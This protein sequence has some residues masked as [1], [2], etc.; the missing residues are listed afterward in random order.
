MIYAVVIIAVVVALAGVTLWKTL[1]LKNRTDFLVAGRKL[2]WTVLVFTLLSSWIGAGSLF[3]GGENAYRN[4]FAALWQPAGGWLG[5]VVIAFIAGRARRFAQFTVPDLLEKRYN[6]T[7]RVLGTIAI[8]ISYTVITS[9]QFKGGG[10]IMHM[11]FPDMDRTTGM[12]IVALF[13]IVFT[14][15][16]GMASVAYMDLVIGALVTVIVV[17]AVPL[18]LSSA[19]GWSGV[20]AS[21]PETHFQVLGNLS[22]SQALGF[23]IPTMLLLVG[24]QGMYQKFFS[25]R[26]ERDAKLAVGGWIV[27]TLLLEALLIALAVIGSA[28][29]KTEAPREIIPITARL[30]LPTI[31]GA[32]LLGGIFAKIIST[33]NNYLFSPATNL[34]HDVYERFIDRNASDRRSLIVSRI[35]VVALGMFALL[36]ASHFES[37]LRAALYAYTVYGAAVTPAVLAVFFWRRTTTAG[38]IS[39]ILLGTI[40]T[41]AWNLFEI[42]TLDAIYPALGASVA[43]LI[44]VSLLTPAPPPERVAPF[45]SEPV[46]FQHETH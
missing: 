14:A 41:V 7:A 33:A 34:I 21:L 13:V 5:L 42:S 9:Y 12:Y 3:A 31:I 28:K 27:G 11:I 17:I 1:A 22:L 8:V 43:S 6:A 19:G 39:S 32:I 4:G 18:V 24:N 37:I 40:I 44:L 46:P 38:A 16:A 15:A 29:F 26:S 23:T 25:A 30:G 45:F 36:Q 35:I 2:P 10:D 20:R